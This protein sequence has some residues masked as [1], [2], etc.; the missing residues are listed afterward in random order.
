MLTRMIERA[1]E[2][3]PGLENLSVLRVWTGFRA[4]TTDKLP[5]IGQAAGPT[6]D[7]SLW[8]AA[9]LEGLGITNAPGVARLVIDGMLGRESP[10]DAQPYSPARLM[11]PARYA[12]A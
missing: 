8:L 5:L 9:G 1:K 7:P 2:Y 10:I 12:H 4:A 3:M 6:N 11:E